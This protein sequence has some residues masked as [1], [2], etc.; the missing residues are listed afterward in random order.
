MEAP[1][2]SV[3]IPTIGRSQSL[4]RIVGDFTSAAS[5]AIK[6]EIIV[7]QDG[8]P[9]SPRFEETVGELAVELLLTSRRSRQGAA[10][11][12]NLGASHASGDYLIFVD[13]DIELS[14][15]WRE[16]LLQAA[17]R[18]LSVWTGPITG[19][20]ETMLASGREARYMARYKQLRD[21]QLV[22]F[23]PGGNS[24][25]RRDLFNQVGGFPDL[26]TGSDNVL[27][28]RL[29]LRGIP[30]HY[31]SRFL[32]RHHHDRGWRIAIRTAYE[33]GTLSNVAELRRDLFVSV[34]MGP[35][36]ARMANCLLAAVKVSGFLLVKAAR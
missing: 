33:S 31:L 10:R 28:K 36:A 14:D 5:T 9:V 7:V 35:L 12:R 27:A 22:E 13:D 17:R 30:V 19:S 8:P 32:V 24:V 2:F 16:E 11:A 34:R 6:L 15:F 25:V 1:E 23:L 20:T 4:A 29:G 18:E 26:P 21:G 3:I